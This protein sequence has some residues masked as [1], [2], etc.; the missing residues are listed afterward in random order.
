M[1]LKLLKQ[2]KSYGVNTFSLEIQL[3]DLFRTSGFAV[4]ELYYQ[5]LLRLIT[6][7]LGDKNRAK[8]PNMPPS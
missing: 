6:V 3:F 5:S 7:I 4:E 8:Q 2:T 1:I